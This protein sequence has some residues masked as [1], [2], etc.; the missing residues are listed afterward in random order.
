MDTT[1]YRQHQAKGQQQEREH[2]LGASWLLG[3]T[4]ATLGDV[5]GE[6]E[7]SIPRAD[8]PG[9]L[10]GFLLDVRPDAE[11]DTDLEDVERYLAE[12][13]YGSPQAPK[14]VLVAVGHDYTGEER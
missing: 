10:L 14:S 3:Y 5:L 9:L 12:R 2:S 11:D 13:G 1:R 7:R 6:L 8:L 4:E